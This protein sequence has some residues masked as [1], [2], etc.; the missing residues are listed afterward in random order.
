MYNYP[1]TKLASHFTLEDRQQ[2]MFCHSEESVSTAQH[3][4]MSQITI[5]GDWCQALAGIHLTE[6]M[7]SGL[8][9]YCRDW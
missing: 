5:I 6:T 1:P 2:W 4:W 7:V 3:T 8:A 9:V